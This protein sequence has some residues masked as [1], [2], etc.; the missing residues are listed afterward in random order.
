MNNWKLHLAVIFLSFSC[1]VL[2]CI[3]VLDYYNLSYPWE[4]PSNAYLDI[5]KL[6]RPIYTKDYISLEESNRT[7]RDEYVCRHF[8]RDSIEILN[9]NGYDSEYCVGVAIWNGSTTR[10]AWIRSSIYIEAT[11]GEI[12]TSSKFNKNYD[13]RECFD[14]N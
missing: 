6:I 3:T 10:H 7:G 1:F 12:L 2:G 5:V 11:T 9:A 4:S 14:I 8:A 13:L